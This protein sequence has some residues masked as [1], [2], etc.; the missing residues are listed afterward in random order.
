MIP[1]AQSQGLPIVASSVG[2]IPDIL[3]NGQAG[4]LLPP[5]DTQALADAIHRTLT[6]TELRK[7]LI[8][9]SLELARENCMENQA[10]RMIA[11]IGSL[12]RKQN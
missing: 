10:G 7:H 4:I 2:G 6:D 9:K 8:D 5:G 3:Q 12:I 1:E 11:G